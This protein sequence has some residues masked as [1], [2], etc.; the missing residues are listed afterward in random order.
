MQSRVNRAYAS[1]FLDRVEETLADDA[2]DSNSSIAESDYYSDFG[3]DD[4][5]DAHSSGSY[6]SEE[7]EDNLDH[8]LEDVDFFTFVPIPTE[9]LSG[10][11]LVDEEEST[12]SLSLPSEF[13]S[14]HEEFRHDPRHI[15]YSGPLSPFSDGDDLGSEVT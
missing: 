14:T 8:P 1:P 4:H 7:G 12:T 9:A 5:S 2:S 10:L 11:T 13:E 15:F 3:W 6:T